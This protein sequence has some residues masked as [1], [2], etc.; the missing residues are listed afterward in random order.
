M[1]VKYY[2]DTDTM[3]IE[4]SDSEIV[5]TYDLNEYVLIEVDKEGRGVSMTVEHAKEQMEVNEFRCQ[6]ATA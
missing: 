5:D 1:K 6:F 2:S 3:L 4:F